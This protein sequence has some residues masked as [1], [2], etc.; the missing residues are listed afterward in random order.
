VS[1]EPTE[2]A[3]PPPE[4][5]GP[6]RTTA[7]ARGWRAFERQVVGDGPPLAWTLRGYERGSLRGDLIAGVTVAALIIPLT[8]GY[9]QV[10]GLPPQ[11]GLYA[12]LLP[13]LAYAVFGSVRRLVAG[14]DAATAALVGAAIIPLSIA[15]DDRMRLASALALLVALIFVGM[16]LA[17][18]GFLADFLSR[19]ILVGYMTG[20]GISVA[21]GQIPKILGGEPLTA[22]TNLV[23]RVDLLGV[24]PTALAGAVG[25]VLTDGGVNLPSV[26]VGVLV[27]VAI[28]VGARLLPGIPVDL[29]ALIVALVATVFLD[30][31]ARGVHVLGPVPSGLPPIALPLISLDEAIALL[32]AAIGIAVLSFAD[33]VLTGRTFAGRDGEET[34]P[35]RE[36]VALAAADLGGGLTSGY[37]VS[38]S[39]SRTAAA[40]AAGSKTQLASIVA[41]ASVALVLLFLAGALR[42]LPTPAL[43][44]VVHG[45]AHR[46]IDL[47]AVRRIWDLDRIEGA[48][49]IAAI[50]GVIFYGTLAGVGV[51]AALAAVNVFRRAA[52]PRIDELG[53]VGTTGIFADVTREP[54]ARRVPGVL[55]VR[56]AG[57]L[58]FAV[59]NPLRSRLRELI[60]A[61]PDVRRV[62][63]D[64]A[65]IVDLDLT[66]A[67]GLSTLRA[68]LEARGIEL[69]LARPAGRLRD[70][71]RRFG[72]E[73]LAGSTDDARLTIAELAERPLPPG[74]SPAASTAAGEDRP[75]S[76]PTTLAEVPSPGTVLGATN[77]TRP[78]RWPLGVVALGAILVV[79]L[80]LAVD[81]GT[82]QADD[83]TD[84]TPND[85]G[86]TY[87][88]AQ[89]AIERADQEIA[90]P[91]IV[92]TESPAEGMVI[93]QDTPHGTRVPE[94]T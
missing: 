5:G 36:L 30:H 7:L 79:S 20:V 78:R 1:G 58:F 39:P 21:I 69:V 80:G 44:A 31:E 91:I 61:R 12:S 55:V 65:P 8:I 22:A 10:A 34:D 88:Q 14:P 92:Q 83:G 81:A 76:D 47:R 72:L 6:P 50:A 11:A 84:S 86:L 67:D 4:S 94:G 71:L 2:P 32:P 56:V 41:S 74:T 15:A 35:D 93:A 49:A 37:P 42:Y 77:D 29:P 82:R 68:D 89:L 75:R 16:R 87:Y 9:A 73:D 17:A 18:L 46:F 13:L 52:Q 57:P 27:L 33:T 24:D 23:D 54:A 64:A 3:A 38:S 60:A 90:Q 48:I 19:P 53:R 51:A 25:I 70:L 59:S 45:A 40:E 63:V 85:R 43:A 62:V 28:L 26:V 66:A